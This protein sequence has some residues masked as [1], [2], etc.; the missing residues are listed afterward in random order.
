MDDHQITMARNYFAGARGRV[1]LDYM[2][3]RSAVQVLSVSERQPDKTIYVADSANSATAMATGE[4]TSRGRIATSAH[5]DRDL[6]MLVELASGR[7]FKTGIVT[8]A[9]VTD[10]SPASFVTHISH[11]NCENPEMMVDALYYNR[12]PVDCSQD[13]R[14]KGGKGK[15]IF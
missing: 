15:A 5:T 8:T 4:I 7:G 10:A 3:V 2:P 11:R 12:V 14:A 6:T 9:S 13:T 1:V